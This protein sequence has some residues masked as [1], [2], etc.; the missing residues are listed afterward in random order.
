MVALLYV[1]LPAPATW[2]HAGVYNRAMWIA[3]LCA[4]G[5]AGYFAMLLLMGFRPRDLRYHV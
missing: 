4:L 1:A 2:L 3:G 5:G